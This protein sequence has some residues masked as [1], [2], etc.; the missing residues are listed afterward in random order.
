M[1]R[2]DIFDKIFLIKYEYG[3]I[4]LFIEFVP[5]VINLRAF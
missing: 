3:L 4:C 5:S 2:W 1:K